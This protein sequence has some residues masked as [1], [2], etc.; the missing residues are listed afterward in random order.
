M[1]FGKAETE[2]VSFRFAK[3]HYFLLPTS[4]FL[5]VVKRRPYA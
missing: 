5:P 1:S 4:Y 2:L 3:T